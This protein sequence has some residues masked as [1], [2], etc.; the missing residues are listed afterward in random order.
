M[1]DTSENELH[2]AS[3]IV[4]CRPQQLE[5]VVAAVAAADNLEVGTESPRGKVVVVA[6]GTHQQALLQ[7]METIES[8]PGVLE[9]IL[10]YHEIMGATEA[11]HEL[12]ARD[13]QRET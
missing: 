7:A 5:A 1:T 11:G 8:L 2:I 3:F 9:C 13:A 10:V 12:L 4:H 6:E